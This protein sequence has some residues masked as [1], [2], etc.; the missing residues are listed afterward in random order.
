MWRNGAEGHVVSHLPVTSNDLRQVFARSF[1]L[2]KE[3]MNEWLHHDLEALITPA[4]G[5]A[6]LPAD[7]LMEVQSQA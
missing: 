2:R 4:C 3:F 7:M 5:T 1:Q 6:A